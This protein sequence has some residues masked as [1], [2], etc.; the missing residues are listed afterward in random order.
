MFIARGV[1]GVALRQEGNVY[2]K[3]SARCR[4]V[5]VYKQHPGGGR[6]TSRLS[7]IN[8]ILA[9]GNIQTQVPR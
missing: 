2:S 4:P 5:F 9:E 7:S 8:I 3:R 1:R 6:K